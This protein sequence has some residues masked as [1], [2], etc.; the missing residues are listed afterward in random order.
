MLAV[1][2]R[3]GTGVMREFNAQMPMNSGDTG[4]QPPWSTHFDP[5]LQFSGTT[6]P[7]AWAEQRQWRATDEREARGGR[8]SLS[9]CRNMPSKPGLELAQARPA[10]QVRAPRS[11]SIVKQLSQARHHAAPHTLQCPLQV[12]VSPTPG[13]LWGLT[14][15]AVPPG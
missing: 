15:A 2:K 3:D 9:P 7:W 14:A 6:L 12:G 8:V 11:G 1:F 5:T 4:K 10:I 13:C